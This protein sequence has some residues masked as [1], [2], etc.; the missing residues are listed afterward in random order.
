MWIIQ[1]LNWKNWPIAIKNRSMTKNDV[2]KI[3]IPKEIILSLNIVFKT[4]PLKYKNK[5]TSGV[6]KIVSAFTYSVK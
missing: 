2:I 6:I 3:T 5:K 1:N 4:W